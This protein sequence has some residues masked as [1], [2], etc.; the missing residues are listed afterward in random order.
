[1]AHYFSAA[2]L[3]KLSLLCGVFVVTFF[4]LASVLVKKSDPISRL[5]VLLSLICHCHNGAGREETIRD[6]IVHTGQKSIHFSTIAAAAATTTIL[7]RVAFLSEI[8]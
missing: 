4:L 6:V 5:L 7:A 3:A 1:L 8:L 2:L